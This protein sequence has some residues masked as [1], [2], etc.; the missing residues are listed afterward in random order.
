MSYRMKGRIWIS[1]AL[2]IPE[3]IKKLLSQLDYDE[4]SNVYKFVYIPW[5]KYNQDIYPILEHLTKRNYALWDFVAVGE[6]G[7]A[8][9]QPNGSKFSIET[10]ITTL[11]VTTN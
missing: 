11:I 1:A 7:V 8:T 6:D 3:K 2:L 9:P 10:V 4:A 5:D